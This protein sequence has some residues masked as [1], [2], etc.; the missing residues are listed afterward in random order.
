MSNAKITQKNYIIARFYDK[1]KKIVGSR[2]AHF[3]EMK[4]GQVCYAP[5]DI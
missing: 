4:E 1:I 2:D 3:S 5:S